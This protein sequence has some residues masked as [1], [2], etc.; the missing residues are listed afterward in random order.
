MIYIYIYIYIYIHILYV[1]TYNTYTY[2]IYRKVSVFYINIT[3]KINN[4]SSFHLIRCILT[5]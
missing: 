2:T 5:P 1:Y 4:I 3:L